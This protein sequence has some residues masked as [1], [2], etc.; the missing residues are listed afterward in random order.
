MNRDMIGHSFFWY[1][2]SDTN[3]H[4]YNGRSE[5]ILETYLRNCG[6]FREELLKQTSLTDQL[7]TLANAIKQTQGQSKRKAVIARE[8]ESI[9]LSSHFQVTIKPTLVAK[10]FVIPKCKYMESKTVPLWLVF[11]N[12]DPKGDPIYAIMK[13][14]DDLRQDQ[15]TLQMFSIMDK[16]WLKAGLDLKM[17]HFNCV[18]TG[19]DNGWI[20]V[21]QN[22]LTSANI[23]KKA[24]GVSE[25]FNEKVLANWIRENNP[26]DNGYQTA[27]DNFIRSCAASCVS[28]Y[29]LGIGDRH[30]DN[31]MIH[32]G[33]QLFH[34]DFG[35]FLGNAQMFLAFK[36]D[37]APFVFTPDMAYVMGGTD[38]DQFRFF[39]ECC[40][41]AY[42]IIRRN[43]NIFINLFGM[44]LST[45]IPELREESDINY[46]REAFALDLTDEDASR[47]FKAMITE[48]LNT[49]SI[50][51]NFAIHLLAKPQ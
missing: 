18:S 26:S 39:E 23:Q 3:L 34:I 31:I 20:E 8:L 24:G 41:T 42:N 12:V 21:V 38:S 36:R 6:T 29:V 13:T 46:L 33:G 32:K 48:S 30:N 22:S 14:G 28:T 4:Y 25:V 47:K 19:V 16:M 43:A 2:K 10:G 40:C 17:I 15:L 44:M 9:Q 50:Q 27:V 51:F 1:L 37:R 11:D 35:K 45:G 5:S 49:K 7:I